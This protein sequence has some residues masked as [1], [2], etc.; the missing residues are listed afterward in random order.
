MNAKIAKVLLNNKSVSCFKRFGPE[1]QS[2]RLLHQALK[3]DCD[4]TLSIEDTCVSQ[5]PM[6]E[7]DTMTDNSP[8]AY[9]VD[10]VCISMSISN[11]VWM[12]V[13]REI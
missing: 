5:L 8:M 1:Q 6:M 11:H 9:T 2:W 7:M 4:E 13:D 12:C 10:E 3:D